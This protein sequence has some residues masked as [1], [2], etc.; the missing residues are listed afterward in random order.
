MLTILLTCWL[1]SNARTQGADP[2]VR[3]QQLLNTSED[4]RQV[5]RDWQGPCKN[6]QPSHLTPQRV[7]GLISP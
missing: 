1:V 6:D 4:R 7:N 2:N 5:R 3:M